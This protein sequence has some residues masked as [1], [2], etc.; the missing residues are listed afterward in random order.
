VA[1]RKR[2]VATKRR[3][4]RSGAGILVDIAMRDYLAVREDMWGVRRLA[5][6]MITA[7]FAAVAVALSAA[8]VLG[9]GSFGPATLSAAFLAA[10]LLIELASIVL[11]GMDGSFK[12]AEDL[13]RRQARDI[14]GLLERLS[15]LPIPR[16]LLG[17]QE[18]A[19]EIGSSAP[20]RLWLASYA[21]WGL[22]GL[23][24]PLI[25]SA[26]VVTGVVVEYSST[27][28]LGSTTILLLG[29]DIVVGLALAAVTLLDMQLP[30]RLEDR[31][32]ENS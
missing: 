2:R 4:K 20:S 24:L 6:S 9:N 21:A 26:L 31:W 28:A 13:N 29:I 1:R 3:S 25:A 23:M 17:F 30:G 15:P 19:H 8:V 14:R 18:R 11:I 10:A 7:V 22:Q 5:S 12:I 27:K 32:D 16:T